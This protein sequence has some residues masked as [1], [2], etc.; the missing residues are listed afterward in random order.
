MTKDLE[1]EFVR[2]SLNFSCYPEV[3][4]LSQAAKAPCLP[5]V[6]PALCTCSPSSAPPTK[7]AFHRY[8]DHRVRSTH[9]TQCWTARYL[10]ETHLGSQQQDSKLQSPF[11]K[12]KTALRVHMEERGAETCPKK[13]TLTAAFEDGSGKPYTHYRAALPMSC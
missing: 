11:R 3:R 4:E 9:S 10:T 5:L 7:W 12:M 8:W 6:F 1:L 2:A 13:K